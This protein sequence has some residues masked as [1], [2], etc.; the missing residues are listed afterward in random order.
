[1]EAY[2]L[3]GTTDI[4]LTT[5]PLGVGSDGRAVYLKDIWPSQREVADAVAKSV[6][7]DKFQDQ[8]ANV[9]D[10]NEAWNQISGAAGDTYA[11]DPE[12]TYVR[13]SLCTLNA[14]T[15]RIW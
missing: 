7:P 3:A 13:S 6:T 15:I 14:F 9:F 8:Y 5:E 2:A 11:W 10:G 1:M 4:D 12:S